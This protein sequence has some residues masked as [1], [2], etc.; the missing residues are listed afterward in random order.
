MD[1]IL[2]TR[3]IAVV[4]LTVHTSPLALTMVTGRPQAKTPYSEALRLDAGAR[5]HVPVLSSL[6]PVAVGFSLTKPS[7]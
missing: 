6:Y 3:T 7:S 5:E 2:L 1:G 4:L